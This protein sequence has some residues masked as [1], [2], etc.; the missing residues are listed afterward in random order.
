MSGSGPEKESR[1][2]LSLTAC[3]VYLTIYLFPGICI[4]NFSFIIFI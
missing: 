2:S 3:S 1:Q 4:W